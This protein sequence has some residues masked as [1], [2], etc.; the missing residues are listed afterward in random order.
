MMYA[1]VFVPK[2][3]GILVKSFDICLFLF[4]LE[5]KLRIEKPFGDEFP[6]AFGIQVQVHTENTNG[7]GLPSDL[8]P[9]LGQLDIKPN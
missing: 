8:I 4:F 6:F 1:F 5:C 7:P 2:A 3:S 9:K